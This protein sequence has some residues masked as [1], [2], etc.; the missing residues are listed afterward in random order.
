MLVER[1]ATEETKSVVSQSQNA[2][3]MQAPS[4]M[5]ASDIRRIVTTEQERRKTNPAPIQNIIAERK[6]PTADAN[7][8]EAEN[9][10]RVTINSQHHS[11]AI[12]NENVGKNLRPVNPTPKK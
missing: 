2:S 9:Q 3:K 8:N 6:E 1:P 10:R 5:M 7:N 12:R 4:V 11:I